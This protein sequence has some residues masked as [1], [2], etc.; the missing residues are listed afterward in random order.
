MLPFEIADFF[1]GL[2]VWLAFYGA[3]WWSQVIIRFFYR[4]FDAA[5]DIPS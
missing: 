3:A 5:S 2:G 1:Q 4:M